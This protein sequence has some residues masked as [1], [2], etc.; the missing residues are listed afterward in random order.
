MPAGLFERR[1][2]ARVADDNS[3]QPFLDD[4]SSDRERQHN[5]TA[6]FYG[7]TE[8]HQYEQ[9]ENEVWKHHQIQRHF[10]DKGHWWTFSKKRDVRRWTLTLITG[11]LCG[12][13]ALLVTFFTKILT[14]KKFQVFNQLMESEKLG[15]TAPGVA[16][17]FLLL[18]NLVFALI[19]WLMVLIEPLASG[20][21]KG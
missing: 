16:F 3:R 1:A 20:S 2:R 7:E 12:V 14:H 10:E 21:G 9:D 13:V 19:A 8:S 5:F 17:V 11:F 4:V 6:R 15:T 18:C